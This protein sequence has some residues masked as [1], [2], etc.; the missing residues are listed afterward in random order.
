MTCIILPEFALPPPSLWLP[1]FRPS[2]LVAARG[3]ER[4]GVAWWRRD[5]GASRV[6]HGGDEGNELGKNPTSSMLV[7]G[8]WSWLKVHLG[9]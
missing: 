8:F 1:D 7:D 6:A 4:D 9:P 3:V 5:V 2:T